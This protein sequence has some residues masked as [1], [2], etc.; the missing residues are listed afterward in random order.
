VR[1]SIGKFMVSQNGFQM[2]VNMVILSSSS[3]IGG[4]S[5]LRDILV[6]C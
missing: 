5:F 6:P 4:G 2:I 1:L 3:T